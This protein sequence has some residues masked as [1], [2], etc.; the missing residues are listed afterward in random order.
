MGENQYK[1]CSITWKFEM[2]QNLPPPHFQLQGNLSR[3]PLVQL[4]KHIY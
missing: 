1:I 2:R 4:M 3:I